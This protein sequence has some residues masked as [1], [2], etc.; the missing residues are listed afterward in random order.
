MVHAKSRDL[1]KIHFSVVLFGLSGLFGKLIALNPLII[2]LGRVFFATL[3]LFVLLLS[4][5]TG[6]KVKQKK[7]YFF[8]ALLGVILV[9][10]W[11]SFFQAIK[12]STVT[13]G[14]VTYSTF[15]VFVTFLE[16]F[17]FKEKPKFLNVV[18]AIITFGGIMLIIPEF[19]FDNSMT[20]GA[21]WGILSGFTFALLSVLNIKYVTQYSSLV[22]SFYQNFVAM[23]VLIPLLFLIRP[24]FESKDIL[25]LVILGVVFTG[26]SHSLFI[27]GMRTVKAQTAS[28][29]ASLEPVYGI[30]AA[31]F[32]FGEIPSFKVIVGSA[33]ILCAVYFGSHNNGKEA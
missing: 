27:S 23:V 24:V 21:L 14:L 29:I 2:V 17:F 11:S 31:A 7:D 25:Y 10:H 28:I 5:K 18:L 12:L 1:L 30:V 3:F 16:P 13:I 4:T 22:L 8:L 26:I 15:P 20:Q 6:L 9:L 19:K 32:L 33:I